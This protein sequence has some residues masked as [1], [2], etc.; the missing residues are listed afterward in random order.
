ME[1]LL[2]IITFLITALLLY[3]L[4]YI[5]HKKRRLVEFT[6]SVNENVIAE[7]VTNVYLTDGT[8]PAEWAVASPITITS[9]TI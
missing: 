3:I 4:Y 6:Q 2:M 8:S 5:L 9:A 1:I 7:S